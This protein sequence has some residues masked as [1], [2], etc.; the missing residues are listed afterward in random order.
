MGTSTLGDALTEA[1]GEVLEDAADNSDVLLLREVNL[2]DVK[3][4]EP[5]SASDY[6]FLESESSLSMQ[7]QN[8]KPRRGT[9]GCCCNYIVRDYK[10]PNTAYFWFRIV[11]D[12]K[13]TVLHC[14]K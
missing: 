7:R 5:D 8:L 4:N 6:S 9:K 10:A 11:G 14:W 12:S 1:H 13:K 3:I 2:D